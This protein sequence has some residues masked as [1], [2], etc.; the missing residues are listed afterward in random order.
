MRIRAGLIA[1]LVVFTVTAC[2]TRALPVLD[3]SW[4]QRVTGLVVLERWQIQAR[5]AIR[6]EDESWNASVRWQ[7]LGDG[8]EINVSAP[9]G[10]GAARLVSDGSQ[11]SVELPD[12]P[13]LLAEDVELLLQERLGWHLPLNG[14]R[15]WLTGRPDPAFVSSFE[16]DEANRLS[17]LRQAGWDIAYKRYAL[18]DGVEL[19]VKLDLVN[20]RLRVRMVIDS[21][22]V[23]S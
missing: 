11:V 12:E 17:R 9:F 5:L 23:E 19:P 6:T 18:V 8:Y 10:Q 22:Q 20:P 4:D 14:M 21:W 3:L 1:G 13:L 16:L 2:S 7:Q 15:Y